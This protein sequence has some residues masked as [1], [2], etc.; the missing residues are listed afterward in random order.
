MDR[1]FTSQGCVLHCQ[2]THSLVLLQG[3]ES[4]LD[5]NTAI[6]FSKILFV[7]YDFPI[8]IE[9]SISLRVLSIR[10][11]CREQYY[12]SLDWLISRRR[13]TIVNAEVSNICGRII[14]PVQNYVTPGMIFL[15]VYTLKHSE[16][17]GNMF[18]YVKVKVI[19]LI[20]ILTHI[21]A[22]PLCSSCIIN[23][24]G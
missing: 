22:I 2:D 13:M 7:S 8:R 24:F 16:Y 10:M 21:S 4:F 17:L 19:S 23:G 3:I 14:K 15:S 6:Y 11:Q 9:Q 5:S 1:S 12:L 18:E 20:S